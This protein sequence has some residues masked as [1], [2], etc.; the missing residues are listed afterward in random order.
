MGPE[1]A[2]TVWGGVGYVFSAFIPRPMEKQGPT[3]SDIQPSV[4]KSG[5][6]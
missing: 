3:V 2:Q 5:N 1:R 6:G 4:S